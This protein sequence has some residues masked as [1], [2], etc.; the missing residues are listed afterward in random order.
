MERG[1]N[2]VE[3]QKIDE[4]KIIDAY[5]QRL[6]DAENKISLAKVEYDDLYRE[7]CT[8]MDGVKEYYQAV[9]DKVRINAIV[10]KGVP[11]SIKVI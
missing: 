11:K 10:S 7:Y 8:K 3:Q 2:M 9:I 6:I 1:L 4:Q 5:Q